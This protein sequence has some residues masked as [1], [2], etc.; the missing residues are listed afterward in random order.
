M[1][2]K[3]Q[4][5]ERKFFDQILKN[6]KRFNSPSFTLYVAKISTETT[7]LGSRFSF[8]A[9]KKVAKQA[10]DRNK[11]RRRGYSVINRNIDKIKTGNFYFFS[12]KKGFEKDYEGLEMDIMKLLSPF[13]VIR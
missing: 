1:L 5:I 8:S 2:P 12:Y 3:K 13:T 11:L 7:D 4:R 9:S 10:V 6:G